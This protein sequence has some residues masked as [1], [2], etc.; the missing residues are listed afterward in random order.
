MGETGR[1]DRPD[2]SITLS[3]PYGLI[4][5]ALEWD[6]VTE[7]MATLISKINR[8]DATL[9]DAH[10]EPRINVCFVVSGKSTAS[11]GISRSGYRRTVPLYWTLFGVSCSHKT[12]VLG[13]SLVARAWRSPCTCPG[14]LEC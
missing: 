9:K 5:I 10:P 2:A 7:P 11:T 14:V 8:Y 4:A 3:G 13:L 6:R 12:S 1:R